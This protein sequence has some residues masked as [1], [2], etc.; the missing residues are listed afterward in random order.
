MRHTTPPKN[1]FGKKLEPFL[2]LSPVAKILLVAKNNFS[3]FSRRRG[4]GR[5]SGAVGRI[6]RAQAAHSQLKSIKR[7]LFLIV[8]APST[9][10]FRVKTGSIKIK[11]A[12]PSSPVLQ[13]LDDFV[14]K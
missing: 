4:G 10:V 3:G 9:P 13:R 8:S 12:R 6:S 11:Q 14:T 5:V 7:R 2:A 1:N